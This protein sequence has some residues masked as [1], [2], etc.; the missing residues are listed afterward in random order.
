MKVAVCV[1]AQPG[2]A[3]LGATALDT[4]LV[5]ADVW[6]VHTGAAAMDVSQVPHGISGVMSLVAPELEQAHSSSMAVALAALPGAAA[7]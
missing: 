7:I 2:R 5:G 1:E 3:A 4:G 6:W